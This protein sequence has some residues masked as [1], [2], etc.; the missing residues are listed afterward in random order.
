MACEALSFSDDG[1]FFLTK[2]IEEGFLVVCFGGG[3]FGLVD[4][5]MGF[6]GGGYSGGSF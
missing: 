5:G 2:I 6:F 3:V 1:G 4:G